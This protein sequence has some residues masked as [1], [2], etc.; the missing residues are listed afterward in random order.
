MYRR[1]FS[2]FFIMLGLIAEA[3]LLTY[4]AGDGVETIGDYTIRVRQNGGDWLPVDAY[5]M[6]I[7][8]TKGSRTTPQTASVAYFDFDGTVEVDVTYNKGTV[9]TAR[10]RPLS[11]GITPVI[12]QDHITFTL[13]HPCNLSVEFNGDIF[14]NLHLFANPIDTNRPSSKVLK[15][16]ERHKDLI[17]FGPGLHK[18]DN[19][20]MEIPSGTTV[21]IDGG[22]RVEGQLVADSVR[23]VNFYGRGIIHPAGRGEGIYIKRSKNIRAD[24]I[25]LTQIPV[26]QSDSV[27]INNVKALSSYGWGDGMNV[28][29]SDNVSYNRVFCRNSD[30][31]ST[32]YATRKGFV[33]GCSNIT[34]ENSVL[35]ADVAH[36]I[37]IGLHGSAAEIGPDAPADTIRNITYRNIDILDHCENQIDYQGCFAIN[38]GDNNIVRDVMFDNIRVEDFRKGQLVNIRIFYNE[39]YCK[40]P[41]TTVDNIL[42]KDVTYNGSNSNMSVICGY[43]DSRQVTN[44]TFDNLVINGVKIH[45][46]MPGKPRWYKTSDLCN[47]FVGPHVRNV[48]FK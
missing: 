29:A 46:D 37:M 23:D 4:P 24:G 43:D 47:F 40:A 39:K 48:V 26:G 10:I 27:S 30:D 13:D 3:R 38:C 5:P 21:Y 34:M 28:F 31:C 25:I 1:F 11:F 35:W 2:I 6:K 12:R 42:F 14:H 17:Y 20:R 8:E 22:A 32:I 19:G 44:V 18:L 41:G 15:H 7:A 33:G 45:D 9:D 16:P 36:P